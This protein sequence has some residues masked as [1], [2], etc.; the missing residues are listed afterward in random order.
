MERP[1]LASDGWSQCDLAN[2]ARGGINTLPSAPP[3][4]CC[5]CFAFAHCRS[6][7]SPQADT[8]ASNGDAGVQ[9]PA[10]VPRVFPP[11]ALSGIPMA[12]IISKLHQLGP[13]YWQKLP[14]T[15]DCT[16]SASLGHRARSTTSNHR[17]PQSS[18]H[19]TTAVARRSPRRALTFPKR[20]A[21]VTLSRPV[22]SQSITRPT[23][24]GRPCPTWAAREG[25]SH[26]ESVT[27]V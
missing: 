15:A 10:F 6:M 12:Y 16:L 1:D 3:P 11:P 9:Q 5:F 19:R 24:V 26:Y 13:Q 20:F 21:L 14:H 25:D 2:K 17:L 7:S 22:P 18:R 4:A 23:T 8:A 27:F